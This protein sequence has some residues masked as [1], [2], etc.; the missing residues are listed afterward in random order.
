MATPDVPG[1]NPANRDELKMGCW[2]ECTEQG[3]E[4]MIFV[5]STE[6]DSVYYTMYDLSASPIQCYND[7]MAKGEFEQYFSYDQ[8]KA[9]SKGKAKSAAGTIKWTWHDKTPFPI[10]RVI[11]KGARPGVAYASAH[12]QLSA[13]EMVRQDLNKRGKKVFQRDVDQDELERSADREITARDVG[14]WIANKF[15]SLLGGLDKP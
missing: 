15:A 1:S 6:N 3:D 4:S 11:K 10:A 12:D 8:T 9:K 2:A 13:A 7:A 5:L 14:N